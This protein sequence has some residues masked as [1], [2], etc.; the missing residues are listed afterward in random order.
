MENVPREFEGR[1]S[2]DFLQFSMNSEFKFGN[3]KQTANFFFF[4]EVFVD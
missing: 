4:L 1:V 3:D 2:S